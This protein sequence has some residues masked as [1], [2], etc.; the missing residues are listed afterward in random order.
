MPNLADLST[1]TKLLLG[2]GVLMFIDLFL[3]WQKACASAPGFPEVC[4]SR[5]G[6][7]GW[8]T[9]VGLLVIALL[10]WEVVQLADLLRKQNITLPVAAG[11]IS[12]ALAAG[13]LLFTILKFLVDNEERSWPAWLGLLLA[14]AIAAGGWMKWKE[15]PEP[16]A[17]APAP[18]APTSPPPS[19]SAPLPPSG[20]PPPP[21]PA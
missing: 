12:A 14:L 3:S 4:V 18:S 6:W 5:S 20:E 21:P 9:L 11:L 1:A 15:T 8:G 17:Y 16:A 7:A 10:V 13:I 19:P 2:A